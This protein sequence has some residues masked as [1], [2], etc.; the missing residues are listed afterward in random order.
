MFGSKPV[1]PAHWER[2]KTKYWE[3][4]ARWYERKAKA[5]QLENAASRPVLVGALLFALLALL[6]RV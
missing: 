2:D 3:I 4:R 1:V 6:V 5:L